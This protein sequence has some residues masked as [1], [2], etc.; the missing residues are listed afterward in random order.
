ME[1]THA[2]RARF[3]LGKHLVA[4]GA[5]FIGLEVAAAAKSAGCDVTV[6]E[7]QPNALGRVVA[8][9]VAAALV[10]RHEDAGVAFR[11]GESIEC[12]RE[13]NGRATA[14]LGSGDE[15]AADL[16]LVGIGG[17]PNDDIARAAGITCDNG[18]VVDEAGRTSDP[19]IFATGD[20]SNQNSLA[21]GRRI[22][23]E[24]W[25]NAQNQ[26]IALGR[27]IAGEPEVYN[28]LPWFWTD[29]YQNNFQ[30]IGVA[31]EWDEIIWR[32]APTDEK[33]TAMYLKDGYIVAANTLNNARD[34]RALKK[35]M[36]DRIAVPPELMAD[37]SLSLT[38]IQK[39]QAA[40]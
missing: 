7:T 10:S 20:V 3:G 4:V 29:Q 36:V 33:F 26:S 12:V 1:D 17:V 13:S 21:L 32:G 38:K 34:I 39:L 9:E 37:M 18:I 2:I 24:S 22:R 27:L 40:E 16:I 25:Q 5:G 23:L 35:L 8:P 30:I 11:F 6:I 28:E 15:I 31:D 19:H 14:L